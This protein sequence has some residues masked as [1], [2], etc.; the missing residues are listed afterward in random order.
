MGMFR[1]LSLK[2]ASD[3]LQALID[4]AKLESTEGAGNSEITYEEVRDTFQKC[5]NT[6]GPDGVT[7]SMID[8]TQ[9]QLMTEC[10][11]RLWNKV[12]TLNVI[13]NKWKLEHR[14]LLPKPE[15]IATMN[16]MHIEQFQLLIS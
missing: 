4:E 6:P 16:V 7:A 14:V 9:R 8:M 10:L 3:N 5:S 15:R 13:P 1:L 2:C 11:F 12:W